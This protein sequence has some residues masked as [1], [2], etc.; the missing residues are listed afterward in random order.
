MLALRDQENLVNTHQTA[1]A[2]KPLNQNLK[3][4]APKTPGKRND[5]NNPLAFGNR[6]VK[7]NG[8]RQENGKPGKDAFVTPMGMRAFT[9]KNPQFEDRFWI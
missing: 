1:A 9:T 4:F 7:G 6:T 2:A 3:Q 8:N 5:E